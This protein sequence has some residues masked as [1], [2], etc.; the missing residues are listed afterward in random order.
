MGLQVASTHWDQ[1][2]NFSHFIVYRWT[3]ECP[4]NLLDSFSS[5]ISL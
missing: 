4:S 2:S 3:L 5:Q 1:S